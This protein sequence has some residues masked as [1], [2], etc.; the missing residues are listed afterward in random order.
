MD[1]AMSTNTR[2][3]RANNALN[4]WIAECGD[5]GDQEDNLQDM[6]TDVMHLCNA[7]NIDWYEMIEVAR[8]NYAGETM[9]L[10]KATQ[11]GEAA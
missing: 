10:G 2:A 8:L 1:D 7:I 3:A 5:Q 11:L 4:T 9:V 6:I